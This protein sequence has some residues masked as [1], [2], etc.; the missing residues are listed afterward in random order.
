MVGRERGNLSHCPASGG[1]YR[2]RQ[3][4][5]IPNLDADPL[6]PSVGAKV[7]LYPSFS[8]SVTSKAFFSRFFARAFAD[9]DNFLI[10]GG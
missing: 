2:G 3:L 4:E 10:R 1:K 9:F 7:R 6:F 5:D 8:R